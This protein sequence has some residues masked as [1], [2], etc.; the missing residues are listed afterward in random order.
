MKEG[1]WGI[2]T[3]AQLV[4]IDRNGDLDLVQA[5]GDVLNG[6][7]IWFENLGK[8]IDW[9]R[10][11]IKEPG[12]DQDFHSLNVADFDNDGDLDIFTG[13]GFLNRGEFKWF[14]WENVDGKGT[15]WT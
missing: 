5:E 13:G 2:Q 6:R 10:H 14:I 9:A 7:V 4:D 15:Q 11:L 8:G 12:Y 3:R 1:L